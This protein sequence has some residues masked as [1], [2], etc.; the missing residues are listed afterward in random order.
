LEAATDRSGIARSAD[1][2]ACR[3]VRPPS[4]GPVVNEFSACAKVNIP[5][6]AESNDHVDEGR[7]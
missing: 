5:P 7:S 3:T 6:Q 1:A 2:T 4:M